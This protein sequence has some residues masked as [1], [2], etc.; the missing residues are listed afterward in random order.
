MPARKRLLNTGQPIKASELVQRRHVE[1]QKAME[2]AIA[3]R[4]DLL[5]KVARLQTKIWTLGRQVQ[6]YAKKIGE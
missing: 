5:L 6:R 4:E 1:A 3:R 2:R